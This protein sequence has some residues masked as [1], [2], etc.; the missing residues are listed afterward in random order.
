MPFQPAAPVVL[1]LDA[2]TTQ[3]SWTA[4]PSPNQA[5]LSYT[6]LR[7]GSAIYTGLSLT[8]VDT[9]LLPSTEYSYAV[10]AT[11]DFGSSVQSMPSLVATMIDSPLGL[12]APTV[13]IT[14]STTANFTWSAP[15][16]PNGIVQNYSIVYSSPA[17]TGVLACV[18]D[19]AL[20]CSTAVLLPYVNYAFSVRCCTLSACAQSA[21]ATA[22]TFEAPPVGLATP[23]VVPYNGSAALVSWAQPTHP[24]GILRRYNLYIQGNI[25]ELMAAGT[26][27]CHLNLCVTYL[28]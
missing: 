24:N 4:P 9:S 13:S 15:T 3:V 5:I 26:S 28:E 19:G 18:T 22:T 16:I 12:V 17:A 11:N 14:G 20:Y 8:I 21:P 1:V 23:S 27:A 10:Q 7:N 6:V 25:P 2:R